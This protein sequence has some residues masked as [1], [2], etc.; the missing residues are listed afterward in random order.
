MSKPCYPIRFEPETIS[1]RDYVDDDASAFTIED[2]R[3]R[4]YFRDW[5]EDK[6]QNFIDTIKTFTEI[7]FSIW[8]KQREASKI[9]SIAR[10]L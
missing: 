3:A 10:E 8:S 9:D 7:A 1:V 4:E 6:L 5:P 2:L